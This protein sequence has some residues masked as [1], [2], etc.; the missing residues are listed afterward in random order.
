MMFEN[1]I[2]AARQ[3]I[4]RLEKF[5]NDPVVVLSIPRGAVPMGITI[6]KHFGW[7]HWILLT[8]K[9]GHPMNPEYAIGAAGLDEVVI[10]SSH[11][12][13]PQTYIETEVAR[14]RKVLQ[15]RQIKFMGN[16]TPPGFKGKT[17][18]IIDDGIA[19][20][21]T[22]RAS[23]KMLRKQQ[24]AKIVVAVPVSPPS[25][26]GDFEAVTDEFIVLHTSPDFRAVGQFYDDFS[27]VTDEE[28]SEWLSVF[29]SERKR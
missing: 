17:L 20:G 7:D 19:T 10:D 27:E 13:I 11:S 14:I 23:V 29:Q 6:A 3:L 26:V 28:V 4:P 5:R 1:R 18:I 2:D 22:M 12:D 25:A 16:Q 24:P 9:I 8:K 21:Y 15:E